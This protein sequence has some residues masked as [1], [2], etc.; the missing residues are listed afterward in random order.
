M[1]VGLFSTLSLWSQE[2]SYAYQGHTLTYTVIDEE[3]KTCEVKSAEYLSSGKVTIPAIALHKGT[4]YSV[5]SIGY[6]AFLNNHNITEIDIPDSVVSIGNSA[7][8]CCSSLTDVKIGHSVTSIGNA[9][10]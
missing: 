4:E 6:G 3:L 5:I 8:D 10:F 1:I 2:F 7:F 9:A